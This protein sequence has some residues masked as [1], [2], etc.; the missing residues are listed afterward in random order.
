MLLLKET[1]DFSYDAPI[2]SE[3]NPKELVVK[4]LIQ[5]A[6][7][8]NHNK[9]IYP[10]DILFSKVQN[11][12]DTKVTPKKAFGELD[13]CLPGNTEVLTNNGWKEIQSILEDEVLFT[14]NTTTEQIVLQKINK[15]IEVDFEGNM[16][17]FSNGKKFEMTV[18]PNHNVLLWDRDN[19]PYKIKADELAEKIRNKDS[20][21][22]HSSLRHS[23][24]F[25]PINSK[26]HFLIPGTDVSIPIKT[27][28]ALFGIWIA[29]GFVS[30]SK[31][32]F[33]N[34]K[35]KNYRVTITQ[36]KQWSI[37]LIQET[38]IDS[39]SD[40][41]HWTKFVRKDGT[42]DWTINNIAIHNYFK[43]FG[44]SS[45][46]FLPNEV[47]TEW[48]LDARETLIEWMLIGDGRN[49]RDKISG[50]MLK[51]YSTISKQLALDVE[52][53]FILNGYKPYLK[54]SLPKTTTIHGRKINSENCQK[55]FTVA[56]NISKSFLDHRFIAVTEQTV[57]EKIYCVNIDNGN[58]VAKQ[59]GCVFWT[60][61]C[62]EATVEFKRVSHVIDKIWFEGDDVWASVRILPTPNGEILKVIFESGS[63]VGI[64]SRALGSVQKH[65]DISIVNDDLHIICWDFVTEPSTHNANM[66]KEARELTESELKK[67]LSK[68]EQIERSI[69]H[70]LLNSF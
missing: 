65:G 39:T 10:K 19:K 14:V 21:I 6:N 4:G 58:F 64:S 37:D 46:K 24:V 3:T 50:R 53:L 38:I 47:F 48:P 61:N 40:I 36:K 66:V 33:S 13:H 15:K 8:E 2:A 55:L 29:E 68:E 7:A 35:R 69:R 9:R 56:G 70:H 27:W 5:R 32:N 26:S 23:F 44:N 1:A 22:A 54:T 62:D 42:T 52:K 17:K 67:V 41:L 34:A 18:S 63:T 16:I 31:N 57:N 30:G 59:N 43:Q 12:I 28:A 60:G 45:E 25:E 20:K 11:Y 51:E 49:R